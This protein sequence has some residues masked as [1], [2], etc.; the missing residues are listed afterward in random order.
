MIYSLLHSLRRH[1]NGKVCYIEI[2]TMTSKNRLFLKAY[3]HWKVK[4][5][6]VVSDSTFARLSFFLKR[7][8][9][10]SM[11][12]IFGKLCRLYSTL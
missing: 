7:R 2:S 4:N 1:Q 10:S 11:V 12:L 5:M 8:W 3:K 6:V 9:K